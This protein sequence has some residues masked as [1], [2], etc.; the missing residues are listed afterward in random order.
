MANPATI[1]SFLLMA[2]FF[3]ACEAETVTVD[4]CGDGFV[5]PG[6][7]C[8]GDVGEN[9]CGSL[10]YYNALGGLTCRP[11]CQFDVSLCGG[12]CGDDSADGAEGEECDGGDLN[13]NSCQ[14][15]GFGGGTLACFPDCTFDVRRCTTAC[16][17]GYLE[18]DE[19][20]DDGPTGGFDGCSEICTVEPGWTCDGAEPSVCTPFC[21]D[22]LAIGD[23]ACDGADLREKSCQS[24]G[25]HGGALL[26]GQDCTLDLA[27]CEEAGRC[28][29]QMVQAAFDEV[30]DGED[31][32]GHTC[33]SLG[34][35]G[36]T[37]ACTADCEQF[38]ESGCMTTGRCGDGVLQTAAGEVCDGANL[39]GAS[40]VSRGFYAGTLACAPDCRSYEEVDCRA[41]GRC[42]D[43]A[44]QTAYGEICEGTNFFGD[45]CEDRGYYGGTLTCS[46]NCLGVD[47]SGCVAA[48]RCGDGV[49]QTAAGEVCDGALLDGQTCTSQGYHGGVLACD[50]DCRA[51]NHDGCA[52]VGRCG[53]GVTQT[54][55]GEQCDGFNIGATTCTSLGLYFGNLY[56]HPD[57]TFDTSLCG[58]VCGDGTTQPGFGEQCDGGD[59]H[60]ASCVSLDYHGGALAC[61]PG[62]DFDL[63]DCIATGRCGDGLIQSGFLEV[64][65]D[66]SLAGE[67]CVSQD[68]FNGQLGCEGDCLDFDRTPCRTITMAHGGYN[69]NCLVR[70]DGSAQCWGYNNWGQLGSANYLDSLTPVTVYGLTDAAGITASDSYTC[71]WKTDGTAWCWGR[72]DQGCLG[73]GTGISRLVPVQVGG[74]TGTTVTKLVT[75]N[76]HTCALLSDGTIRCWGYGTY[77]QLGNG[78]T[79]SRSTAF[80]VSGITSAVDVAAG[81]YHTCAVLADG[82][83]RCWGMGGY[84]R[85]G[86]GGTTQQN[87]PVVVTGL[88]NAVS[89]SLANEHSC[90]LLA[91]GTARCWGRNDAGQLGDNSLTTALTPVVVSNL[92]NAIRIQTNGSKS[93]CALLDDHTVT[94]WGANDAGQLGNG[95]TTNSPVPVAVPSLSDI[96]SLSWGRNY[97]CALK[98]GGARMYCWGAN[99]SGQLGDQT[100]TASSVPVQ[101]NPY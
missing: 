96:A 86:N 16:G 80:A 59:L 69:S 37:L 39:N 84:G 91:D 62:C 89:V 28:G 63:T 48:G 14:G 30:C 22:G 44:L 61:A 83:G 97:F 25:F 1:T 60:G 76:L 4:S 26:C 35:Y 5:D 78:S 21:G 54:V 33:G 2:F 101:V 45:S 66:L 72:N 40:C 36:G 50:A 17:N 32:G 51:F 31:L 58:G 99:G 10:G 85:L 9:T 3:A 19:E 20:C 15:L 11:D 24:L 67:T 41:A 68:F 18:G 77:G 94:C 7:Q 71:A 49:I 27:G 52:S 70:D 13:S 8:D 6:E 100:T 46:P 42:G 79:A 92:G 98:T 93:T 88:A 47:T 65:D 38:D 75:G 56:C 90:A 82:T 74:L 64:C 43:G 57:C 81:Y 73:D 23:E 12:R 87:S 55:Y 53:D 95:S 34:Y 29:D